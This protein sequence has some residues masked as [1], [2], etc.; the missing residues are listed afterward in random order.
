MAYKRIVWKNRIVERPQTYEVTEND[1]G[2]ITLTPVTGEVLQQGTPVSDKNLN[3]TEDGIQKTSVALDWL[4][5]I[6]LSFVRSMITS[7]NGKKGGD[8]TL[9][10]KDVKARPDDWMPSAADVGALP[11][12]YT[13]PV[14]SVNG[15]T[16]AVTISGAELTTYETYDANAKQP[17]VITMS[18]LRNNGDTPAQNLPSDYAGNGGFLLQQGRGVTYSSQ[19]FFGF[20]DGLWHRGMTNTGWNGWE[21]FYSTAY[22]QSLRVFG[23]QEGHVPVFD[24]NGDI[25]SSGKSFW[26]FTRAKMT[27][28]GTTLTI[29]TV[30]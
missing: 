18:W 30:S 6:V 7:I 8:I 12:T 14:T 1:D 17:N 23:A 4:I 11:N 25:V 5:N 13:P 16:G 21:R 9:T 24:S 3:Y 29:T 10:A 20:E 2:T 15:K 26:D 27:L 22:R 19:L 28:S